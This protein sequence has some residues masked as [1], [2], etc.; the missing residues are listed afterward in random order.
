MNP[1]ITGTRFTGCRGNNK[2][3]F[4]AVRHERL[5]ENRRSLVWRA[6]GTQDFD[7]YRASGT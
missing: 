4:N 1:G 2:H 3:V 6:V 5:V 7:F